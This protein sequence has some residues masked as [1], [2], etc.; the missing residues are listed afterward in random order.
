[1][2]Q[3]NRHTRQLRRQSSHISTNIETGT[4]FGISTIIFKVVLKLLA[5]F[6]GLLAQFLGTQLCSWMLLQQLALLV[7][8]WLFVLLWYTVYVYFAVLFCFG[9]LRWW[10]LSRSISQ[11]TFLRR[12]RTET[13]HDFWKCL[14]FQYV[15]CKN[16][17]HNFFYQ[18]L[19]T[20]YLLIYLAVAFWTTAMIQCYVDVTVWSKNVHMCKWRFF[21]I[22]AP[23]GNILFLQT[24]G[25]NTEHPL[26]T[27]S[28]SLLKNQEMNICD[29][30]HVDTI[31]VNS[32]YGY[33]WFVK[34]LTSA[35]KINC[36]QC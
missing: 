21:Q 8:V 34:F 12:Y 7:L 22:L 33:G 36:F 3:C 17:N 19:T 18:H 32:T 5:N 24:F 31:L 4:T 35:V 26:E 16:W 23:S 20:W 29:W 1:M 9:F 14:S 25:A 15:L 10:C 2:G 13:S 11:V 30:W 6:G 27:Q 28:W